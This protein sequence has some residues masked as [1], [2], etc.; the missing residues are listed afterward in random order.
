MRA[1]VTAT[2]RKG[3]EEMA[4]AVGEWWRDLVRASREGREMTGMT[5][6]GGME[7]RNRGGRRRKRQPR[8]RAAATCNC[9]RRKGGKEEQHGQGWPAAVAGR[10]GTEVVDGGRGDRG[11]GQ[12]RRVVVAAG[13]EERKSSVATWSWLQRWC[14]CNRGKTGQQSAQLLRRRAAMVWSKRPLLVVFNSLLTMVKTVG[15]ERLLWVA[16]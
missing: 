13:N 3:W 2:G 5:G 4:G 12:R 8:E 16:M 14:D 1:A 9:C 11:R 6:S 7:E 15:S 10:R